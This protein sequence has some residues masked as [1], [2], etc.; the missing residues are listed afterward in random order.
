MGIRG[1]S[2]A[3]KTALKAIQTQDPE[4]HGG[5]SRTIV[6]EIP[7]KPVSANASRKPQAVKTAQSTYRG[8]MYKASDAATYQ[9]KVYAL[10]FSL[11][12]ELRWKWPYYCAVILDVYNVAQDVDNVP[13]CILDGM[14]GVFYAAD[15]RVKKLTVNMHRDKKGPRVIVTVRGM[16]HDECV[17]MGFP[18]PKKFR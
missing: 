17:L 16:P 18:I 13:K 4:N 14:Q 12:S 9:N 5:A 10:S 7:G 1:P 2:R 15:S 11:A 6:F 3:G 8:R